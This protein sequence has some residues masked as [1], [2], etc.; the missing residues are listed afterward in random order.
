[1]RNQGTQPEVSCIMRILEDDDGS[2][3][4]IFNYPI[5]EVFLI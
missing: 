1:L 3:D 2:S 4:E 5:E